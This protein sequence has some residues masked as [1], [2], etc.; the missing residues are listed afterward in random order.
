M[1]DLRLERCRHHT[2]ITLIPIFDPVPFKE[3]E[4]W[5]VH[6][7]APYGTIYWRTYCMVPAFTTV[8]TAEKKGMFRLKNVL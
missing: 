4:A 2:V 6:H 3:R 5:R 1:V 8:P 7:M